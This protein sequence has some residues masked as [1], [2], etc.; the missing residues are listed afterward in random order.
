MQWMGAKKKNTQGEPE[1][2]DLLLFVLLKSDTHVCR[3]GIRSKH[4]C[5]DREVKENKE[6]TEPVIVH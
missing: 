6:L 2:V 4:P 5:K 1:Q 3:L